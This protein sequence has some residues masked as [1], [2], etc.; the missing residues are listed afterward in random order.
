[1]QKIFKNL[2]QLIRKNNEI[3][4]FALPAGTIR[5]TYMLKMFSADLTYQTQNNHEKD[6]T[7]AA[8]ARDMLRIVQ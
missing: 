7:D 3:H 2:Y 6:F 5:N 4:I 8:F 1:M